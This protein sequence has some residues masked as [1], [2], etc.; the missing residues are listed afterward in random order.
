MN[1]KNPFQYRPSQIA[2]AL[3]ALLTSIVALL[4]LAATTFA[5]GTFAT[6]GGWA[7]AAAIFLTPILVFLQK[8]T[9]WMDLL[10][11][12]IPQAGEGSGGAGVAADH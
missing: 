2:K 3:I 5:D 11:R 12:M 4:G 7:A 9:P 10:D 6:V 8:A 1:S